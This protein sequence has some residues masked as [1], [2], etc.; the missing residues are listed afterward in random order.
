MISQ[1]KTNKR[2]VYIGKS[3]NNYGLTYFAKQNFEKGEYVMSGFGQVF[4]NQTPS[5]SI[6]IDLN[7]HF[8]PDKW[9]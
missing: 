6:Q 7:K 5:K 8:Y 1:R 4:P 9:G 3:K 2:N